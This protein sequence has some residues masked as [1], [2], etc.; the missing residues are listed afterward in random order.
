MA[1]GGP[2]TAEEAD[3]PEACAL[4]DWHEEEREKAAAVAAARKQNMKAESLDSEGVKVDDKGDGG[5]AGQGS[6]G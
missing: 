2:G 1:V 5:D 3:W 6:R 4:Q